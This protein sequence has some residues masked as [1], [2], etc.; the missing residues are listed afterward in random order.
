[1]PFMN[2]VEI[3][4]LQHVFISFNGAGCCD[5]FSIFQKYMCVIVFCFEPDDVFDAHEIDPIN[6]RDTHFLKS[7]GVSQ[8]LIKYL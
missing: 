3:K 6:G 8:L 2:P 4:A 7:I 1:M 5:P